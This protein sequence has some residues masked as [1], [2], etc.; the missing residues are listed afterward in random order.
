MRFLASQVSNHQVDRF[1]LFENCWVLGFEGANKLYFA[2]Q[3]V[4][5][6]EVSIVVLIQFCNFVDLGIMNLR[7]ILLKKV[8]PLNQILIVQ[9]GLLLD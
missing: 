7:Y 4:A 2:I 8:G 9:T 1:N 5:S 3:N 6:L